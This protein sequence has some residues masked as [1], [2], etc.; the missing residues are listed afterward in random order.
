M[1]RREFI[2]LLGGAAATWPLAAHAQQPAKLPT[3][4]LLY[5]GTQRSSVPRVAA[6]RQGLKETGYVEGDNVAFEYRWSEG[7]EDR[8]PA[9]AADL[10]NRKVAVIFAN[11][12]NAALAAK[13]ATA[14]IPIVF[15]SAGDPVEDGLVTSFNRPGGNATGIRLF[16]AD[17]VAKRLQ[18][19]HDLVPAA[20]SVGFLVRP[21]N[22]TST[23]QKKSV[24]AAAATIGLRV[25][26]LEVDGEQ[27]FDQAFANLA[28]QKADALLVGTDPYFVIF[29]EGLVRRAARDRLPAMYDF[30]VFAVSGGLISYGTDLDDAH[31][32]MGI[33]AGRILKGEKPSEL[34]V[35]QP[36][37]FELVIN[38][39]TAK[40]LG[41]TV[42]PT[43]LAQADE[44][45]E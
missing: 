23:L 18:L 39:G 44:V 37:K 38:V 10:I 24:Q 27:G 41:L 26:V 2:T 6:L 40:T 17:I 7:Q 32:L 16:N 31:R 5:N 3:I 25:L 4:G 20:S 19:L 21:S 28:A 8:L 34:P 9:M 30:S 33:Y 42:P 35:M 45:V 29:R 36:T 11:S 1:Q 12:I 15:L 43:L 22:P 14:T 13:A